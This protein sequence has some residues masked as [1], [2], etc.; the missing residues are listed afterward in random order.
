MR[1]GRGGRRSESTEIM[2]DNQEKLTQD[3]IAHFFPFDGKKCE[4]DKK[5]GV[6]CKF[7]RLTLPDVVNALS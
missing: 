4:C 5:A 7:N 6:K 1:T 3:Y 2:T